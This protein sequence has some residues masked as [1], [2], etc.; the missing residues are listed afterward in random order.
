MTT[1]ATQQVAAELRANM[2]RRRMPQ[3]ALAKATGKHQTYWSRRMLGDVALDVDDLAALA[4]ILEI[5]V[6]DL[7]APLL[8]DGRGTSPI[9]RYGPIAGD[10]GA[11]RGDWRL[12]A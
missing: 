10:K 11:R 4:E 5:S 8:T 12:A 1:T 3:T 7:L 9:W 2:A 6:A